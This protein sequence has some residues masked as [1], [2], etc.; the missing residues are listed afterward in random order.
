M[1]F[2]GQ[3]SLEYLLLVSALLSTL[4]L[5]VPYAFSLYQQA[6]F[7]T[8]VRNAKAFLLELSFS[9]S[10]LQVFENNSK[11][12]VHASP[13]NFWS[14]SISQGKAVLSVESKE[15][16]KT[17]TLESEIPFQN[18]EFQASFS[19]GFSLML[20]KNQGSILIKHYNLDSS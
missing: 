6:L 19:T 1:R 13:L 15:V 18:L 12:V 2:K 17:K 20:E 10:D 9:L 16:G 8:D 5:M 11:T 14:L 3:L 7:A 4:A